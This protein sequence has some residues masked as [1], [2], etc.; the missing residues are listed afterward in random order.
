MIF[1]HISDVRLRKYVHVWRNKAIKNSGSSHQLISF[2]RFLSVTFPRRDQEENYCQLCGVL[3]LAT[4][5]NMS[6]FKCISK[7]FFMREISDPAA[8]LWTSNNVCTHMWLHSILRAC[9]MFI[10]TCQATAFWTSYWHKW[11]EASKSDAAK[12]V[13][14]RLRE[15]QQCYEA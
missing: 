7:Y 12:S 13:C 3:L 11:L 9:S 10:C 1:S 4:G 2:C 8:H 15:Y 6:S 14:H 5:I